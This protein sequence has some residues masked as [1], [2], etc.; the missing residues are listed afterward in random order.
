LIYLDSGAIVKLILHEEH[1]NTLT[2]HLELAADEMISSEL[3]RAEVCR[4][5][6]RLG[7]REQNRARSDSLLAEIA[8]LPVAAVIDIVGDL[9]GPTLRTLDALH[10]ATARLL[11]PAVRQFI[12]Y[13]KRLA[14]AATDA[15]LPLVMPGVD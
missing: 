15:G 5:L 6:I 11:G 14:R 8:R 4:T 10:L 13:D 3:A 12:T 9:E 2:T 1:S 7:Q